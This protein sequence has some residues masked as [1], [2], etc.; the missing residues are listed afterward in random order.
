[1]H[2]LWG[3][4]AYIEVKGEYITIIIK[5]GIDSQYIKET[6]ERSKLN[7]CT[8]TLLACG[9]NVVENKHFESLRKVLSTKM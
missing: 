9:Q 4:G 1:M 8:C 2:V 7:G 6:L 5:W 3:H